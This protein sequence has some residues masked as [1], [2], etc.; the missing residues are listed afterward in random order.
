MA[1][2]MIYM[3]TADARLIALDRATGKVKWDTQM[4]V[5]DAAATESPS[6]LAKNDPRRNAKVQG[7]S[8]LGANMA[9]LVF[10]G[11]VIAGVTGA[12]YPAACPRMQ[13]TYRITTAW[14]PTACVSLM[15]C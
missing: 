11:L 13:H 10:D 15:A 1:Y 7:S 2:G 3:T 8:G 14:P 6:D 5:P 4:A 9:P 12:G